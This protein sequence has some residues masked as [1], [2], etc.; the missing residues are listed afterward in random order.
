[1]YLIISVFEYFN[2]KN[3]IIAKYIKTYEICI[4]TNSNTLLQYIYNKYNKYILFYILYYFIYSII[5]FKYIDYK[6]ILL[7]QEL[8]YVKKCIN[9]L[10]Y[11]TLQCK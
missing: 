9:L 8:T 10:I 7:L 2:A 5:V 3:K 4:Y 6:Y 11:N 1:M